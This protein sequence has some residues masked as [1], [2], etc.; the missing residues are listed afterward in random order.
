MQTAI[1]DALVAFIDPLFKAAY[2]TIPVV[3]D[4]GPFDWNSPPQTFV[5]VETKF[6]AGEQVNMSANPK[7]RLMGYVYVCVRTRRGIGTREATQII[8]WFSETLKFARVGTVT[9]E[10]PEPDEPAETQ[11]WYLQDLKVAFKSD[12]G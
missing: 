3:Y 6:Y 2:P 7:R 11:A 4:N 5:E 8:D 10:A 9:L 1:R 12:P